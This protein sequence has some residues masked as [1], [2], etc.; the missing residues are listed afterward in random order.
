MP[1]RAGPKNFSP[2]AILQASMILVVTA[3]PYA[4]NAVPTGS[5]TLVFASYGMV[6]KFS[7]Y[8]ARIASTASVKFIA[9]AGI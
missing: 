8:F 1:S 9:P 3:K 7:V 6:L 5:L 4:Q 2:P